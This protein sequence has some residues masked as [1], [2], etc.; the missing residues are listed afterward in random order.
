MSI[1][2]VAGIRSG[3]ATIEPGVNAIEA[4]NWRGKSSLVAAIETSL[5]TATPLTEGE[6][7]GRVELHRGE[8]T[9]VTELVRQQG[10]VVRE[11]DIV[12][13]NQQDRVL[14]E[15][16]AALGERNE[17]RRAVREGE[18]LQALLSRPLDIEN[19]DE[20]I[21]ELRTEREAIDRELEHVDEAVSRLPA[22]QE[23]VTRLE[24][25]VSDL[26]DEHEALVEGESADTDVE[27]AR[28]A[29]SDRRAACTR[30]AS[31]VE[32]LEGQIDELESKIEERETELEAIEIPDESA[33]EVD[34][35]AAREDL[36]TLE[37]ELD[38]LRSV[39]NANQ[40]V[41]EEER[42][43]LLTDVDRGIA[44]D[45]IHCWV[46]GE[47]ADREDI[48]DRIDALTK[49]I[50]DRRG[51]AE[52]LQEKVESL[53]TEHQAI[54][55]KRRQARDHEEEIERLS[56]RLADR[57]GDL[58]AA[59]ARLETL[60]EEVA[61]LEEDVEGVDERLTDVQS[62]LKYKESELDDA[63]EELRELE[64]VADQREA[65][66]A[67]REE[68]SAEIEELRTRKERKRRE[69]REA[70]DDAI[71]TV[72]ETFE[73]G[74]EAARLTAEFDLVVAREGREV[75]LDA[76]S[77]GEVELLGFVAALAGYEAFDVSGRVPVILVD[78]LGGLA[79]ENLHRLIGYLEG[80]AE[81][82]VTTAYPEQG[83]YEWN[84]ISPGDWSVVSDPEVSA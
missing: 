43:D 60:T 32:G 42:M 45:T 48:E 69:A 12:L 1:E 4:S 3:T 50:N 61:S 17:L 59:S 14:A 77:E 74:F 46:C 70:F 33:I 57:Q 66:E 55:E 49:E 9:V 11:G 34:L 53:S 8:D 40:R 44:S 37:S 71:A 16:F 75:G 30:T 18:N 63:V 72:L 23:R 29:L 21:S 65:I 83:G 15:L 10:D 19:I 2:N 7:R 25:E 26:Q 52:D 79:A 81:Y 56:N 5:G 64:G 62:E 28:E 58:E 51:R 47:T 20:R 24:S 36:S 31:T 67:T 38:L 39:Y 76:L 13:D 27:S 54:A 22:V 35:Q 41:M 84:V 80:R 73:P 82:L 78:G 6:E 68:L